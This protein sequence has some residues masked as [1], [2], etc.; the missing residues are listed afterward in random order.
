M[1]WC[2]TLV[3]C[4]VSVRTGHSIGK[5]AL[6]VSSLVTLIL[7][8]LPKG[9]SHSTDSANFYDKLYVPRYV[10]L[11]FLCISAVFGGLF[12]LVHVCVTPIET[13]KVRSF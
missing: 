6:L 11:V 10:I 3:L 8:C 1:L 4:W 13:R 7:V 12:A 9:E 2:V 5:V